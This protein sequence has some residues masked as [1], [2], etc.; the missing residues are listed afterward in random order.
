MFWQDAGQEGMGAVED[1]KIGAELDGC[2]EDGIELDVGGTMIHIMLLEAPG[3]HRTAS[4]THRSKEDP[5]V[6]TRMAVPSRHDAG[7]PMTNE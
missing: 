1:D 6:S 5:V 7:A 3:L 4:S 2:T